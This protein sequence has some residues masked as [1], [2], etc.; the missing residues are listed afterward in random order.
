MVCDEKKPLGLAG[1]MGGEHSGISDATTT[2]FLEG[3]FWSPSVIQGRSRRLGFVSDAGFRFER[4]VDF[5][6]TAR[7][8][9]RAT[10]LVLEI[11]GGRAGPLGDVA[12]PLPSR[13]PV[14]VRPARVRRLLGGRR[15]RDDRGAVRPARARV[16]AG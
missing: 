5:G 6:N 15:P 16:H 4:G 14:R 2:V 9:E 7:A 11:C 12:G 8:V 13:D 3:A 1:I 10:Q